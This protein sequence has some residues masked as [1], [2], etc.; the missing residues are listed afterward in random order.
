MER[1]D[2]EKRNNWAGSF[3]ELALRSPVKGDIRALQPV[4]AALWSSA[5]LIGPWRERGDVGTPSHTTTLE[6][7][8]LNSLYGIL[9]VSDSVHVGCFTDIFDEP[10]DFAWLCLSI[11][12]AM[13]DRYYDVREP[14]GHRNNPWLDELDAALLRIAGATFSAVPYHLGLIGEEALGLVGQEA[15]ASMGDQLLGGTMLHDGGVIVASSY[16]PLLPRGVRYEEP[17]PGVLWLPRND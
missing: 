5:E 16:L 1:E 4:M 17:S 14:L 12:T 8:E 3:Y 2:Y 15:S 9:Q 10:D 6:A 7:G 11:P 13:L